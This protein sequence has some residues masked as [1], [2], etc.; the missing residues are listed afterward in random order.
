MLQSG[1]RRVRER[2]A[3]GL[4]SALHI[5]ALLSLAAWAIQRE[6]STQRAT[7]PRALATL[8]QEVEVELDP[9]EPSASLPPASAAAYESVAARSAVAAPTARAHGSPSQT[10]ARSA[11]LDSTESSAPLRTAEDADL[12]A[13]T[14]APAPNEH[15]VDKI[16]VG[17]GPDAWQRWIGSTKSDTKARDSVAPE[18][19]RRPLFRAPRMSTTGGLQEGLEA[20]DRAVGLGPAGPVLSALHNAA[21]TPA[22]PELGVAVFQVTVLKTGSVEISLSA[23]SDNLDGWRA[24]AARATEALRRSPPRIPGGRAGMRLSIELKAEETMPNGI[25]T[26]SLHGPRLQ[27]APLR[28]RSTEAAQ[29]DLKERNPVAGENKQLAAGTKANVDVPGVYVAGQGKVCSYRLGLTILGLPSFD[30]GCDP[31]NI[32][33]RPARMVRALVREEVLF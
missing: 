27:V 6:P 2:R 3:L 30:G 14:E 29:A 4:A 18:S 24:V 10:Q 31:S 8:E 13:N 26:K 16:D 20:H 9:R 25:K 32:G 33:A 17:L 21:H 15:S 7:M 12:A 11:S 28:L 5:T 22:A 1:S 23:A 19:N